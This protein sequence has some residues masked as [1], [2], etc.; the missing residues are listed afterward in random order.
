VENLPAWLADWTKTSM[1]AQTSNDVTMDVY[2]KK[3]TAGE[4]MTLGTNGQSSYCV[5][6]TV[7]ASTAPE[8]IIGDVNADG[9]FSVADAVM[10]QK[11]LLNSGDLT[12][13]T[14]GDLAADQV[15]DGFDLAIMKRMLLAK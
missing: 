10:M 1:T 2:S 13:W 14:A 4:L 6:Y 12:D 8:K 3:V 5:N 15:I 9:Q 7:F 11:F